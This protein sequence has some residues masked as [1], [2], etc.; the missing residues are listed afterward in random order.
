M[1]NIALLNIIFKG[2][3]GKKTENNHQNQ[4]FRRSRWQLAI[5]YSGMFSAILS[6][7]GLAIY[8][9][10]VY[11]NRLTVDREIET[12]ANQI[13][14]VLEPILQESGEFKTIESK[15]FEQTCSLTNS[16]YENEFLL[17]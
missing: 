12:V 11:A 16:C 1:L 9:A 4:L 7:C 15:I 3:S 17:Y 13:H 6:I 8:E 10:I 2:I 5:W 14:E